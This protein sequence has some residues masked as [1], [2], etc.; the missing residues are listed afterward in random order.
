VTTS[1]AAQALYD[2]AVNTQV[3]QDGGL[4][5]ADISLDRPE[6][7]GASWTTAAL[8]RLL[9]RRCYLGRS[10]DD[11]DPENVDRRPPFAREDPVLGAAL[12][13]ADGGRWIWESGWCIDSDTADGAML[14]NEHGL[15]VH[16]RRDEF[17]P[18]RPSTGAATA[19]IRGRWPAPV[20]VRF[21]TARP[22]ASPGFFLISGAAGLAVGHDIVRW[23]LDLESSATPGVLGTLVRELDGAG[24]RYTF[25]VLSDPAEYPR[26]DSAVLY[27]SRTDLAK[28]H[29]VVLDLHDE[30][31]GRF[32]AAT[33]MF[34]RRV[35]DGIGIAEDPPQATVPLSFGQ[36][37]CRLVAKGLIDA[38]ADADSDA[39]FRAIVRTFDEVGISVDAPHLNPGSPEFDLPDRNGQSCAA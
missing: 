5:Q 13:A 3:R 7:A 25:K 6:R 16:A 34:S 33:P 19:R 27:A 1:A 32:R 14:V 31:P 8:V 35:R 18:A 20:E 4:R 9:Y 17:R 21:P 11:L 39:R 22:Y 37:R 29:A 36:H 2:V 24:L 15:Q 30:D 38:G 12:R 26:P 28:V 10:T 23:Y